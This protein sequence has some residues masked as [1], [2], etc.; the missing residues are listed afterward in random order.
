MTGLDKLTGWGVYV[1][2]DLTEGRGFERIKH[3]CEEEA[4]ARR[5]ARGANVQGSDGV[6]RC[7]GRSS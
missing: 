2:S 5:L 3:L 6:V 7:M 4:T 1:N